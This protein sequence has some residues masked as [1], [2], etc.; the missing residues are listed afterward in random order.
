MAEIPITKADPKNL[1][2]KPAPGAQLGFGKIF[3]DYLFL[4]DYKKGEGWKNPRI[5]PYKPFAMDPAALVLHYGQ[6]IFEGLKAYRWADGDIYLFRPRKNYERM[7]RSAKRLCLPEIDVDQAIEATRQLVRLEKDWVPAAPG[8]S[9]Y[10]RPNMIATEAALGVHVSAECL[11]YIMLGPVGAYYPQGFN[12]VDIYLEEKYIR[13]GRG[14]LGEAK[15]SANYAASLLAQE[16]AHEKG[17]TQVLWLDAIERKYL[18]EVGTSNIFLYLGDEV[19]TPPLGG[20]ILP[21][22][23]R[24][25]VLHI[26]RNWEM[27]V[28]ERMISLDEVISG[29]ESGRVKEIFASGTAAVISPV[30]KLSYKGKDYVINQGKVGPLAQK[31]YDTIMGIQYGK[32]ED[33]YGWMLKVT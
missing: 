17:F 9:L 33:P 19:V 18:E 8:A 14:G 32:T 22:I 31:L 21:G 27:K 3:T 28:S 13:A 23:T 1:K 10:I 5:E 30:G 4:M 20:T 26:C 11:F 24:E 12:P 16:E 6:E 2:K 15:T 7:N 25:S 29:L